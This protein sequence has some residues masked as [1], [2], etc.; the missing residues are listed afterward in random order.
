MGIDH[1]RFFARRMACAAA[2]VA[3]LAGAAPAAAEMPTDCQSPF[4]S[5]GVICRVDPIT[6]EV[7]EDA[8]GN[9]GSTG[10]PEDDLLRAI[11]DLG[12]ASDDATAAAARG[13]SRG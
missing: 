4:F 8:L 11:E 6:A 7:G 12:A 9:L 5:G 1:I 10:S 13:R 2:L 3:G